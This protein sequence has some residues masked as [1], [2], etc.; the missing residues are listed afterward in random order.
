MSKFDDVF[1]KMYYINGFSLIALATYCIALTTLFD[2]VRFG[3]SSSIFHL[4]LLIVSGT[5]VLYFVRTFQRANQI[6]KCPSDLPDTD[7]KYPTMRELIHISF[8]GIGAI[9][10]LV[11]I[12]GI[13]EYFLS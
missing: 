13:I 6:G 8:E 3:S 2:V 11:C 5:S 9:V 1:R 7:R 4:W 12:I 10:V